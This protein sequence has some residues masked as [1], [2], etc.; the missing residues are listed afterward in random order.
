MGQK[1]IGWITLSKQKQ[2][3]DDRLRQ[4]FALVEFER[5]QMHEYQNEDVEFFKANPFSYGLISIGLGKTVTAGTL[6]YDLIVNGSEDKILVLGPIAVIATSWPDEFRRWRHLAALNFTVLREDDDDPRIKEAGRLA[7]RAGTSPAEA[8]TAMRRKIR[9]ELANS[10]AQIHLANFEAIEWL[11]EFWGRDWPYRVVIVDE[12]SLLK[13]HSSARWNMLKRFRL[14]PGYITRMHLLTGTPASEGIEPF[15]PLTFLLDCGKRFGKFITHYREK[16]FVQNKYSFKLKVREG[17]VEEVLAK[18]ADITTLRR[19]QDYFNVN[20]PLIVQRRVTMRPSETELYETMQSEFIVKLPDGKE[21]EAETAAALSQKLAQMASGVLYET[22]LEAPEGYDPDSDEERPDLVKVRRV[23]SIHDHKI[24]MLKQIFDEMQGS[25]VL[26][27]YQHRSSID[28]LVKAF[29][30]GVKWDKSGKSKAPWNAGRIKKL[31]M[32]PKSGG[33]GQNL[34]QGG[35]TIVFFDIP[36]SR[37][38]F[39]Q[40]IGRLDRQGQTNDVTVF[41]LVTA[42]TIDETMAKAQ[43]EKKDAEEEVFKVLRRMIG[44]QRRQKRLVDDL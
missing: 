3:F 4:R 17:A 34:Q 14:T 19:R 22:S 21:I 24:E 5:S 27:A 26:V 13:S 18:I 12:A 29:P 40:L 15:F 42:G 35:S 6:L 39:A 44:K 10:P 31:F 43:Q 33:H 28:R 25:P 36:W 8:M 2:F 37:D 32:H 23:H 7:R 20:E 1:C 16:Y 38:Q 30:D 11:G 41:L 9:H